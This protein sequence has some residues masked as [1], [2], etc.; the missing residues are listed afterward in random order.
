M[1]TLILFLWLNVLHFPDPQF[2]LS[3]IFRSCIFSV[4]LSA[5]CCKHHAAH[6]VC[7][8]GMYLGRVNV[9]GMYLGRVM[10]RYS[11]TTSINSL[12]RNCGILAYICQC[13]KGVQCST[14]TTFLGTTAKTCTSKVGQVRE[15]V[16]CQVFQEVTK[17]AIPQSICNILFLFQL[18]F[19]TDWTHKID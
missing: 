15:V 10:W 11:V 13:E 6:C 4:T 3:V 14:V 9:T 12:T 16:E 18:L 17:Q 5:V 19:S 1:A 7:V 2:S 8:T